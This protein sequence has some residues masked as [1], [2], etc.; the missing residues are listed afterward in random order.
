MKRTIK[1]RGRSLLTKQWLFGSHFTDGDKDY[2]IPQNLLGINDYEDYQV[3]PDTVGQATGEYESPQ[4]EIYEGD[5]L[6]IDVQPEKGYRLV[7]YYEGAFC[8]ASRKELHYLQKGSHPYLNDYAHMT[9]LISW[10]GT[11]LV[12]IVDNI[13][14][15]PELLDD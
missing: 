9:P 7:V 5:I 8:L 3:D 10:T 15:H 4:L 14:T 6:K 1:F 2:V 13:H 12:R 11:G